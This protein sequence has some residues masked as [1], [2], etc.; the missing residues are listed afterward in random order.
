M[1]RLR[2]LFQKPLLVS[3]NRK[4]ICFNIS[5]RLWSHFWTVK[6]YCSSV[7]IKQL[8]AIKKKMTS[9]VMRLWCFTPLKQYF[10]YIV[11]V[12]FICGKKSKSTRRK[13]PT[14]R[15]LL[16]VD[17]GTNTSSKKN[18][19]LLFRNVSC[20]IYMNMKKI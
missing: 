2:A 13:P 19:N 8:L 4:I 14:C 6:E 12:S 5:F 7:N 20:Y 1:L 16:D 11:V 18:D 9:R 10:N 15:H 17:D 3:N